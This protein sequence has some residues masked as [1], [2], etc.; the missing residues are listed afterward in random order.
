MSDRVTFDC[1]VFTNDIS[2]EDGGQAKI[3]VL[4]PDDGEPGS[5]FIR[6]HSWCEGG[7]EHP[8][9]DALIK[10]GQRYRVTIETLEE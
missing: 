10:P 1:D 4:S 3:A 9:F 7:K 2:V 5:V 8:E 6:F